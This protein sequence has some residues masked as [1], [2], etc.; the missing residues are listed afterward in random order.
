MNNMENDSSIAPKLA[1][2]ASV[3]FAGLFVFELVRPRLSP[4]YDPSD[5]HARAFELIRIV[6]WAS[7][8]LSLGFLG[9][10]SESRACRLFS[11]LSITLTC[12]L[13][14]MALVAKLLGGR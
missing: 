12:V 10:R 2:V 6:L 11:L 8:A 14:I 4:P 5:E 7:I 3:F 9:L 1:A 13:G